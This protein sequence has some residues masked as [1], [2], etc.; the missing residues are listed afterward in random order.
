MCGISAIIGENIQHQNIESMTRSLAHRGPDAQDIK[1][2]KQCALGHR[3]LSIIDLHERGK[4]PMKHSS[5]N[6]W[7]TFNGEI[8]NYLEL[9][10]ELRDYEFK[11]KTDTE[12]ILAAYDAWG[13]DC[14]K[15]FNG[16]F[17]FIINDQENHVMW[18][19][20]D[21]L[22]IKPL[23]Y[24][25]SDKR[26]LFASEIKALIAGGYTPIENKKIITQYL[27]TGYYDHSQETFFKDVFAVP[28]AHY[29]V[30]QNNE[31]NFRQ[32]WH[33]T[34]NPYDFSHLKQEEVE[35]ELMR[36]ATDAVKIR[37]RADTPIGIHFS[38]GFD[39]S[40][41]MSIAHTLGFEN[42]RAF[43]H[44]YDDLEFNDLGLI[45]SV[46]DQ[47]QHP[48]VPTT[49][50]HTE[51][52][53]RAKNLVTIEDQPYGGLPTVAYHKMI[54]EEKNYDTIVLLEGQGVD[55][56]CAGYPHYIGHMYKDAVRQ[57][58]VAMLYDELLHLAKQA[59]MIKG[60]QAML[61]HIS[62]TQKKTHYDNTSH[63]RPQ[64]F[65]SA[66][67][68]VQNELD[69]QKPFPTHLQN[70]QYQDIMH[71]KIPRVLR[72]NDHATMSYSR[73][74]RVPFL[75]HRLVELC[76]HLPAQFKIK[77]GMGKYLFRQAM[78]HKLPDLNVQTNKISIVAP[79][80]KWFQTVL[81]QSILNVLTS[82]SFQNRPWVNA[83]LAKQ[84]VENELNGT[85]KNSF[86]I[87]Q[88]INLEWWFQKYID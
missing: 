87:W 6:M 39:S 19:A 32:Y 20:R 71:T 85:C 62:A 61:K 38:G 76:M 57:G 54:E 28:Q 29:F 33:V 16:M 83:T 5:K 64:L 1:I 50:H 22:G 55:E 9:K 56:I 12:V 74:L 63:I 4:Q 34:E 65:N 78:K 2:F 52:I 25:K 15:K 72:F 14:V 13:F 59:G 24:T 48:W 66:Y 42:Q 69:S 21:R 82:E 53:E 18:G 73:E 43:T 7:I 67:S 45:K 86:Y 17:A 79:Q 41:L 46:I 11:T 10:Q 49:M 8:Y 75:D 35:E 51:F 68:E 40:A 77:H 30:M 31:P 58:N 26:T 3:R 47:T 37:L 81:K 44:T 27:N 36:V 60:V 84:M 23:Y 70:A 80:T 88:L